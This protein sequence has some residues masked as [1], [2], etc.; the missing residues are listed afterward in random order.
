[1][2][3]LHGPQYT[4]T[5]THASC[6]LCVLIHMKNASFRNTREGRGKLWLTQA[7]CVCTS[8]RSCRYFPAFLASLFFYSGQKEKKRKHT[9][10]RTHNPAIITVPLHTLSHVLWIAT[11]EK[12]AAVARQT[13]HPMKG[14]AGHLGNKLKNK[15]LVLW[16]T[17]LLQSSTLLKSQHFL[18]L[19][20]RL[21][22]CSVKQRQP[23]GF[24]SLILCF[25]GRTSHSSNSNKGEIFQKRQEMK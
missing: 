21:C 20:S 11:G 17:R 7:D 15:W 13:A 10:T 4:R 14:L 12:N 6:A 3:L 1:M 16:L 25:S 19:L 5:H 24:N 22:F 8:G 9:H 23:F 2:K 18:L